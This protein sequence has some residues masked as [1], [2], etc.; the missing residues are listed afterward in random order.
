MLVMLKLAIIT[1]VLFLGRF[2]YCLPS[3]D[4]RASFATLATTIDM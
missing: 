2:R 4:E 3:P 1:A